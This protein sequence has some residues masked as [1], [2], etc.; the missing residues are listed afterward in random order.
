MT[1]V[2][3]EREIIH[4]A[5]FE[6]F[7]VAVF[8]LRSPTFVLPKFQRVR[9][10]MSANMNIAEEERFIHLFECGKL[11]TRPASFRIN[12]SHREHTTQSEIRIYFSAFD[13]RF[14]RRNKF[15]MSDLVHDFKSV[16]AL[17]VNDA[18]I[19]ERE[20]RICNVALVVNLVERHPIFYFVFVAFETSH[21]ETNEHINQFAVS[22]AAV[23][24]D[25]VIRHFKMAECDDRFDIVFAHFVKHFVVKFQTLFIRFGI[26]TV[27]ENSRPC[28]RS[29]ETFETHFG[30]QSDVLFEVM[31]KIN[32]FMIRI[33][34]SLD[35][36][37]GNFAGNSV[38]SG[39]HNVGNAHAFA[40]FLPTAFK[41]MSGNRAAPQEI[42]RKRHKKYLLKF[43]R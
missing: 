32:R 36:S 34:F 29:A 2:I 19:C 1:H 31:I 26:V 27:R 11:V 21:R 40:A 4:R 3:T 6:N 37:V 15:M 12:R 10:I 38:G 22:P 7:K 41:L 33:I 24:R 14:C 28:N 25:E 39:S 30:K 13:N 5:L 23:F 17:F 8:H 43:R 35:D 18:G 20:K 42:F 16:F 9:R